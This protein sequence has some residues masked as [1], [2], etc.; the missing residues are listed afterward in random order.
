MTKKELLT[1]YNEIGLNVALYFEKS[2]QKIVEKSK[3]IQSVETF[4]SKDE[5]QNE[6]SNISSRVFADGA[7]NLSELKDFVLNFDGC[8]LKINSKNTVFS[9]GNSNAR[10]MAIG[11]APGAEEDL[12]GIPFC[13]QSGKLLDKMFASIGLYREQ[14][15][16]ITNT[17]FWRPPNNRRPTKEELDICRP[18]LEKHIA[19]IKP[20]LIIMVGATAVESLL[21]RVDP[22]TK[23]RQKY[24]QY[25]NAYLEDYID[26]TPIFHPAYLLRQQS[27]KPLAWEDLKLIKDKYET[28]YNS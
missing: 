25:K 23:I 2:S 10:I 15:L 1:W 7:S 24:F 11:E 4:I 12:K 16:Y 9:D 8:D 22:I 20:K 14:N 18:F 3:K 28:L 17:V 5:S 27:Q 6:K 26:A 21:G 13:G 19:L